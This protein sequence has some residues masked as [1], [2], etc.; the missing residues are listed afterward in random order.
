MSFNK[1]KYEIVVI[2]VSAGGMQILPEI[3]SGIKDNFPLPVIIVN[4]IAPSSDNYFA[5]LLQEKC[6]LKV[7]EADEKELIENSVIYTSPPN[8]HLLIESDKTFCLS[9]DQRINYARPSID[10]L[11]YSAS[12]VY[13]S[14]IISVVL[15]GANSDGAK[16][17]RYIKKNGG[18]VIV[19]DPAT[20]YIEVMPQ[21]VIDICEV[22]FILNPNQIAEKLNKL[23]EI[24][25]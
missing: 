21:S 20:A 11:F 17:A 10:V 3:L 14:R 16:G 4:H 19:Q 24:N 6:K 12:D 22:D 15:T 13:K 1:K 18:L 5:M 8:Y 25:I 7:K 23:A 2:G 9:V